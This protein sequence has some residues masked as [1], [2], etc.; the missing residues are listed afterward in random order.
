MRK[1]VPRV[2]CPRQ[3]DLLMTE[4]GIKPIFSDSQSPLMPWIWTWDMDS[5]VHGTPCWGKQCVQCLGICPRKGRFQDSGLGQG[6]KLGTKGDGIH[7]LEAAPLSTTPLSGWVLKT[8]GL[9]LS[10]SVLNIGLLSFSVLNVNLMRLK[11]VV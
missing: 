9:V 6:E 7:W 8:Q 10:I 2:T 5:Q 4:V 3:Q 11:E 1:V